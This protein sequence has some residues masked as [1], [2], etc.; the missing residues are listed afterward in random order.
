MK[1]RGIKQHWS[2]APFSEI[3]LPRLT[4]LV[5]INGAGKTHLLDAI[6]Q[7]SV[8][9][10]IAPLPVPNALQPPMPG[11]LGM[12]GMPG[13]PG[14]QASSMITVLRNSD[15]MSEFGAGLGTDMMQLM[16][17]AGESAP[18]RASA[19]QMVTAHVETQASLT[20]E[21]RISP[22]PY[23]TLMDGKVDPNALM[24]VQSHAA[25]IGKSPSTLSAKEF[26]QA[27]IGPAEPLFNV[28]IIR[29]M[30][31]Y[32]DLM[33]RNTFSL[34][35]DMRDGTNKGLPWDEFE[36][37]HG[38]PPWRRVSAA[39]AEFGLP[40]EVAEPP[41]NPTQPVQLLLLKSGSKEP[42]QFHLL[43]T[44]EQVLVRFVLSLFKANDEFSNV[45]LPNVLLMDEL[46][47]SLHPSA[48]RRWLET[49][50]DVAVDRLGM[51]VVLSTH[52]PTTVAI[53]P[54]GSIF[55]MTEED[56]VPR[57]VT[58]Q[59]AIDQ[60]TVG[61]PMISI[62]FSG[63]RQV[64]VESGI[65]VTQYS[66]LAGVLKARLNLPRT[67]NFISASGRE[68]RSARTGSTV[69][70]PIVEAMA[71]VPSVF[72]M[73]DWDEHHEPSRKMKVLAYGTHYTKENVLLDP[74]LIAVLLMR[75]TK[76]TMEFPLTLP[77]LLSASPEKL[78]SLAN[79][80]ITRLEFGGDLEERRYLGNSLIIQ[81]PSEYQRMKG[82]ALEE[83]IKD[84]IPQVGS[85][86]TGGNRLIDALI[87]N[88]I[89]DYP[90][91]TPRP[92]IDVFQQL[93]CE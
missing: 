56:R 5:G 92:I 8:Q 80:V 16:S 62:D 31:S 19:R 13:M 57:P 40:F 72:G 65:D 59:H 67:L 61:L 37:R 82:H 84:K 36:A 63:Q 6:A 83:R 71:E 29:S 34:T 46:D 12:P 22:Y 52:S 39:L 45:A 30:L 55:E 11:M 79:V 87:K 90:E 93:A 60:L 66:A 41:T 26:E 47:A 23:L 88:V 20:A 49:I 38:P 74:L 3:E 21:Q 53:A 68:E 54:E 18:T 42:I 75:D 77:E 33:W 32:R 17:G 81:A 50:S 43:S 85:Y 24:R 27:V 64:F 2:I 76:L 58:K 35:E 91:F 44:G 69:I 14:G 48:V 10:D 4:V 51:T 78:Q 73:L 89:A 7:G 9:N 15:N 1:L 70:R 86:V 28:T 25:S